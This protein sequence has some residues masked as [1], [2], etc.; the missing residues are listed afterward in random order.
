M[1][2]LKTVDISDLEQNRAVVWRIKI[3]I[4]FSATF[5]LYTLLFYSNPF[6][7]YP[8]FKKVPKNISSSRSQRYICVFFN[9]QKLAKENSICKELTLKNVW[10]TNTKAGRHINL[11][12]HIEN[13]NTITL[14]DC[15]WT[16]GHRITW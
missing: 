11:H 5:L 12:E 16:D 4:N 7:K 9:H 10:L 13:N 1:F 3:N 14:C 6:S 2:F 8:I 15:I